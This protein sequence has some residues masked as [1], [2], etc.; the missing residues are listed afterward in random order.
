MRAMKTRL[1]LP[2]LLLA[3]APTWAQTKPAAAPAA[4]DGDLYQWLEETSGDKAMDWVKSRNDETVHALASTPAFAQL[5]SRLLEVLDS[6]ARIPYVQRMGKYLY[7]FWRDK[8]HPRGIWRRTTLDEYRKEKPAWTVLLDVDALGKTEKEN[9]VWGGAGCLKPDYRR[10]LVRLSR[11]GADARVMREFDVEKRAFLPKGFTLPEA[12]SNV[13]WRDANSLFLGTDFGP[14]AMTK[15]GY[16]RICK[17]WKRGTPVSSAVSIFAGKLDDVNVACNHDDTPGFAR[18]FVFR[19]IDRLNSEQYLLGRDGSLTLIDAPTDAD[20]EVEREWL[21]VRTRTPWTVGGKSYVAGTL[22][23]A[24][25]DDWMAGKREL[26]VLFEPTATTSLASYNWT[27]HHLILNELEDVVGKVEVLTPGAGEWKREPLAGAPELSTLVA[28]GSDP[29]NSDEYFVNVSGYLRPATYAR[30]VIGQSAAED[31]KH[32]P[33]F[34]D[35]SRFVVERRFAKSKDG[36][37]VPYFMISPKG[38]AADGKRPTLLYGYGGFEVSLQPF[39]SGA[40]GRAWLEQG[41]VYVVAN[42]RGGGEYGPMWH[43]A[44]LKENRPR[45]YEDFAAVAQDL[46]ATKVTSPQHLGMQGGSNGGLLAGNMLTR[47]GQLFGAVVS[48]VPLLDMR[49]YTH[50]SAGASWI[51]EYGDPDQPGD[52]SFI[53]TFSPY[54]I[55]Q[56]QSKYPPSLFVTS[57]R[58][59]RVGPAHARKMAAK[60][61]D[62]GHDVQFFENIQGGHGAAVDN[63][64][65]AFMSALAYTFLWQHVK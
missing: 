57:T 18:D 21:T 19:A 26:T 56:K 41:G 34:F 15:S 1:L 38:V 53:K 9:W 35:A 4:D 64:E 16:P 37:R 63:A 6:D 59:D 12:K 25:F 32:A 33:S 62:W 8:E 27:R 13:S 50:L 30:G 7:N 65:R 55:V 17:L 40:I 51:G 61:R 39:Y 52:W 23:A 2:I 42:I 20:V 5:K 36:T 45:A 49:R 46:F 28:S 10:C 14:G 58:D 44:A 48:E 54:H 31:L 22:L 60:M 11:G 29:D 24:K 3:A 43:H 47:Y